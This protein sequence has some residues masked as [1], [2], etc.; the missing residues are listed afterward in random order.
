MKA[1]ILS[2]DLLHRLRRPVAVSTAL[3]MVSF[4]GL[5]G[6]DDD[7]G[8][9]G[10]SADCIDEIDFAELFFGEDDVQTIN[11]GQTRNGSITTSDVEADFGG[12]IYYYDIYVFHVSNSGSHTVEVNPSGDF[13]ADLVLATASGNEIA[14]EDDLE[15]PGA[16][17][18]IT[19]NLQS[20]CYLIGVSSP[21][22]EMTGSYSLSV[23][24]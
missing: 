20:G 5:C 24:R 16:T 14:Y 4:A 21:I 7:D 12:F 18:T 19:S 3:F 11:V 6:D 1:T 17:E 23:S 9:T 15:D 22:E 2:A 8:G 10:P 13:D